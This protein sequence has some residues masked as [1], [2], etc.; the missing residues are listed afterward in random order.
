MSRV[1]R[2]K[3]LQLAMMIN[4]AAVVEVHSGDREP[5][6]RLSP[7]CLKWIVSGLRLLAKSSR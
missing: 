4:E 5:G 7:S 3:I 6:A 1:D 2:E